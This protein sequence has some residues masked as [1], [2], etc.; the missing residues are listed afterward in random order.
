MS[1]GRKLA[2]SL[3]AGSVVEPMAE[4]S[5]KFHIRFTGQTIPSISQ[6]CSG[7]ASRALHPRRRWR[8]DVQCKTTVRDLSDLQRPHERT[9]WCDH[10]VWE[11]KPELLRLNR[12]KS[13]RR[14]QEKKNREVIP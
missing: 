3:P 13:D 10:T 14:S 5:Y 7:E 9:R 12:R 1:R 8:G 4:L 11:W 6:R 2:W